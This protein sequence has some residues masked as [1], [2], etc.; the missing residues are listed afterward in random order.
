MSLPRVDKVFAIEVEDHLAGL[1]G[2]GDIGIHVGYRVVCD[3]EREKLSC[4]VPVV[5]A[6]LLKVIGDLPI[7]S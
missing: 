3:L 6:E 4:R 1:D 5:V 2:T 7:K